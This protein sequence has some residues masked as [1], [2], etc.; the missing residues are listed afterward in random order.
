[1]ADTLYFYEDIEPGLVLRSESMLLTREAIVGFAAMYDPQPF[2]LDEAAGAASLLG[3]LAASGWQTIAVGMRLFFDAF[4]SKAASM[5]SPGFDEIRWLRPVRPGDRLSLVL[6]VGAKRESASRP[7]RGFVEVHLDMRNAADES[8]MTQRGPVIVQ[9]RGA[10]QSGRSRPLDVVAPAAAPSIPPVDLML[11]SPFDAVEV[12]HES[13]LGAQTFTPDAIIAYAKLYDPQYF[14]LDAEAARKSHFG[15]LIASG[16][17]TAAFW[18]KHYVA[19]RQRSSDAR[20]A[21]GLPVAVGGPSPGF[22]NLKWLRP[23]HAGETI[24]YRL[25]IKGKRALRSGWGLVN[26]VN[27]GHAAD[28]SLAFSFDARLLWP[29]DPAPSSR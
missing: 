29:T 18:M 11:A 26:T 3:G 1:M 7:D 16:W 17:Q 20:A 23:V 4:V 25:A 19:A 22:T 5:G 9:K 8:V 6:T 14:H 15:G 12:G 10:V 13:R 24:S 27:T 21:A 28:G 2:H